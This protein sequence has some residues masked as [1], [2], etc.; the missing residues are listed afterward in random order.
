MNQPTNY[1]DRIELSNSALN[2]FAISPKHYLH[3]K[4]YKPEP[5]AAMIFGSAFH[6]FVLEPEK[7]KTDY[8][9]FNGS[10]RPNKEMTMAAKENKAWKEKLYNDNPGK[11]QIDISDYQTLELM[12]CCILSHSGAKEL[13]EGLTHREEEIY[14]QDEVTGLKM[15]GKTDGRG[16][17][18]A[19]DLKTCQT[20]EP[21]KF[22]SHA[23]DYGYHR[24]NA[25]YVDGY[26]A[27]KININN[28]FFIAIESNMPHAVSVIRATEDFEGLGRESYRALLSDFKYWEKMGSPD[29]GY[30]WKN[31][32]D[33]IFDAELPKWIRNA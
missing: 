3:S 26:R 13:L 11:I 22:V 32:I 33:T 19:L 8:F 15:R 17:N 7:F 6:C 23:I 18:Y 12:K 14:W 30:E 4:I 2:K 21:R 10:N 1:H 16:N 28:F 5:T 20:A 25:I 24:Q 31:P 9:V 27:N 29:V